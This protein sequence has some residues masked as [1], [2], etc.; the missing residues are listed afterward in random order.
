[1]L[2]WLLRLLLLQLL[3]ML[4]QLPLLL[5]LLLLVRHLL[6]LI[7]DLFLPLQS[8]PMLQVCLGLIEP[9]RVVA[10]KGGRKPS[11]RDIASSFVLGT[12]PRGATWGG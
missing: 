7:R 8:L 2:P 6:F 12:P 11:S 3:Q 9:R 10:A 1:M 4:L 5:L